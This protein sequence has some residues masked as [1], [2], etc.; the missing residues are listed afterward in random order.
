MIRLL[1]ERKTQAEVAREFGCSQSTVSDFAKRYADKIAEVAADIE[2]E[3]AGLW[4]AEKKN[5]VSEL[6]SQAEMLRQLIHDEVNRPEQTGFTADGEVLETGPDSE[7]V[8]RLSR[9][10]E[11]TLRA[12]AEELGQ[13]PSRVAMVLG[14]EKGKYTI[15]GVDIEKMK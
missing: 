3:F 6:E 10:L 12:V 8:A 14:D 15:N 11:G 2:N 4:I 1:A 9:R 7:K 5:R 13:L